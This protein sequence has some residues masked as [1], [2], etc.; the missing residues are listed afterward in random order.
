[1]DY[2]IV[3]NK[4]GM[5]MLMQGFPSMAVAANTIGDFRFTTLPDR[6]KVIGLT[7]VVTNEAAYT[8][9]FLNCRITLS[10]GAR[11]ILFEEPASRFSAFNLN[12]VDDKIIS[13]ILDSN[14]SIDVKVDNTLVPASDITLTMIVY[15]ENRYMDIPV[16]KGDLG[17]HR[18]SFQFNIDGLSTRYTFPDVQAVYPRNQGDIKAV[19]FSANTNITG[20]FSLSVNAIGIIVDIPLIY[21]FQPGYW[22]TNKLG[23]MLPPGGTFEWVINTNL[24]LTTQLQ[25]TIYFD[26]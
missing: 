11:G 19:N 17:L 16:T 2:S 26:R 18:Q 9:D 23:I 1:M 7:F 21:I 12:E 6:G 5:P 24:G 8:S 25:Q 10:A 20:T 3:G 22:A 13:V 14:Q 4:R 15:Y